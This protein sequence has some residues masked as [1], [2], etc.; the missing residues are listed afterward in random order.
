MHAALAVTHPPG[1]SHSLVGCGVGTASGIRTQQVEIKYKK[2]TVQCGN[3]APKMTRYDSF[4]ENFGRSAWSRCRIR[5]EIAT[6]LNR[7]ESL[8]AFRSVPLRQGAGGGIKSLRPFGAVTA[9]GSRT[10]FFCWR[11]TFD[12]FSRNQRIQTGARSLS[13]SKPNLFK[14]LDSTSLLVRRC[15]QRFSTNYFPQ[16][17]RPG[18]G[19]KSGAAR[20]G[21]RG[22]SVFFAAE[23]A[24][25]FFW[26]SHPHHARLRL[27][28]CFS[29]S[30]LAFLSAK[31]T[32]RN[33]GWGG[34]H[35]SSD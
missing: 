5:G 17:G 33:S 35:G 10:D 12:Y 8:C 21:L 23:L 18:G 26:T 22:K 13:G 6:K 28:V 30:A 1:G 9:R 16:P 25:S 24:E 32:P 3:N 34:G 11:K 27:T 14:Q 20:R 15:C 4:E 29:T 2:P 31:K 7:S 19:Q